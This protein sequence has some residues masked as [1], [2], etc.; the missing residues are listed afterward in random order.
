MYNQQLPVP[1]D[2]FL[3]H[4]GA[5]QLS[6]PPA[7]HPIYQIAQENLIWDI[8][9]ALVQYI[10]SVADKSVLRIAMFNLY[11]ENSYNNPMYLDLLTA[12]CE[13]A[14]ALINTRAQMLP[15]DVAAISADYELPVM[16]R[17]YPIL[18][19]YLS[20]QQRSDVQR[21]NQERAKLAQFVSST[22][23]GQQPA[24]PGYGQQQHGY[25]QSQ[26]VPAR[27]AYGQG[28]AYTQPIT[29]HRQNTLPYGGQASTRQPTPSRGVVPPKQAPSSSSH[30]S[31]NPLVTRGAP[32]TSGIARPVTPNRGIMESSLDTSGI[33][34]TAPLEGS[35]D[36]NRIDKVTRE[37]KH[38]TVISE[39]L[40]EL[41]NIDDS[42]NIVLTSEYPLV[43][44]PGQFLFV[45]NHQYTLYKER[46]VEY[47]DH[48]TDLKMLALSRLYT[49]GP[50]EERSVTW[51]DLSNPNTLEPGDIVDPNNDD[52]L[53]EGEPVSYTKPVAA[54]SLSHGWSMLYD[55][56]VRLDI[57]DLEN[58]VVEGYL[59]LTMP[60]AGPGLIY[61]PL[62]ELNDILDPKSGFTSITAW[63]G[64]LESLRDTLPL[65]IWY[66]LH[67]TA[68]KLYHKRAQ[69]G[70]GRD[71]EIDSLVEDFQAANDILSK[72]FS[73]ERMDRFLDKLAEAIKTATQFNYSP[74]NDRA[75]L[76]EVVS[77]AQIPWSAEQLNLQLPKRHN[78]L[79]ASV[80]ADMY[81]G[82]LAMVQRTRATHSDVSRHVLCLSDNTMLEINTGDIGDKTVLISKL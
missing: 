45:D 42:A 64:K 30:S 48:E 14:M 36:M 70:L 58:R 60:L 49:S 79:S 32:A 9:V 16:V 66:Y 19:Q 44:R 3:Y 56:V 62:E 34:K 77:Y 1:I 12:A 25:T 27:G 55:E 43:H 80:S 75:A 63:I 23:G 68:T 6:M 8:H 81:A 51:F 29:A 15:H 69:C 37:L 10:E 35:F 17:T 4:F 73:Q 52:P 53:L 47:K 50:K 18:D 72:S 11:A 38:S 22:M 28:Q 7:N 26:P 13:Y 39:S 21:F 78:M 76:Y 41:P 59:S 33:T 31:N 74:K 40:N 61:Q 2:Q 5:A 24:Y 65:N 20:P 46:P 57:D 82:I 54:W 67:D 71:F